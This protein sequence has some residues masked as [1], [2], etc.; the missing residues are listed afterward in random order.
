MLVTC[1]GFA[2]LRGYKDISLW[3]QESHKTARALRASYGWTSV[4]F[5]PVRCFGLDLIEQSWHIDL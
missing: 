4:A 1:M 5:K 3:A 2:T